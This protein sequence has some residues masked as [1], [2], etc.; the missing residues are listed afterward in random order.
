MHWSNP[1]NQELL[2]Y[3][4]NKCT[5]KNSKYEFYESLKQVKPWLPRHNPNPKEII[6]YEQVGN[7][8]TFP[9]GL[10]GKLLD[11]IC[12][13]NGDFS[14]TD[15]TYSSGLSL[16]E[17]PPPPINLRA[18]QEEAIQAT[19]KQRFGIL[20]APAGS[21]KTIIALELI[22]RLNVPTL[23]IVPNKDLQLQT[24]D[25]ARQFLSLENVGTLGGKS[26]PNITN[27]TVGIINSVSRKAEELKERFEL[28]IV[29]ECHSVPALSYYNT[30]K[31]LNPNRMYG[32]S[33]SPD[34]RS[35]NLSWILYMAI[36][37]KLY[38]ITKEKLV[39]QGLIHKPTYIQVE[40]PYR[41]PR[42]YD[43]LEFVQHINHV[44]KNK[45]RNDFILN[46]IRTNFNPS[47][48][49]LILTARIQ[50]V[51]FLGKNL[52]DLNPLLYHGD[53]PPKEKSKRLEDLRANTHPLVISTYDSLGQGFDH[54]IWSTLW[55]VSPFSSGVR[56][57]QTAGRVQR[58]CTGKTSAK[59][60]DFVDI[61]DSVLS[62]RADKRQTIIGQ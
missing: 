35:D 23:F 16:W 12:K 8:Y 28:V 1:R 14:V 24:I 2:Q 51:E 62:T 34:L 31:L 9:R 5:A 18:Y 11:G 47:I 33:A 30:L 57:E 3:L 38:T 60:Y 58:L 29:D 19:L 4:V 36:G 27:F 40:T 54:P 22:R 45:E 41:P 37:P 48:P 56:A 59:V 6:L 20:Q 43:P 13:E 7:T 15:E 32:L 50:H 17:T 10:F 21:G 42:A 39:S 44:L 49:S 46:H 55:L 52:E 53:M 61:H 25:R 26:K